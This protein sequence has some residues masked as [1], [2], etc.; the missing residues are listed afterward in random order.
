MRESAAPQE[1]RAAFLEKARSRPEIV[2]SLRSMGAVQERLR[3]D[4]RD[5]AERAE[6]LAG[7]I[8]TELGEP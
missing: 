8:K 5:M 7:L 1:D 6:D 4:S 2:D 3:N